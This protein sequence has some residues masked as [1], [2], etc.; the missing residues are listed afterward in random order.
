MVL[1]TARLLL[2][3]AI[4]GSAAFAIGYAR[5]DIPISGDESG[6]QTLWNEIGEPEDFSASK[7]RIE[8]ELAALSLFGPAQ[9]ALGEPGE[10]DGESPET[11][12]LVAIA[13]LDGAFFVLIDEGKPIR[14]KLKS[15]QISENGWTVQNIRTNE[16]VLSRGDEQKT[17]KLF[18]D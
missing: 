3:C 15:G 5:T 13:N 7:D 12:R 10:A 4:A 6:S 14:Q 1:Q 2:F 8:F 18:A 17:L 16:A 9:S 11:L